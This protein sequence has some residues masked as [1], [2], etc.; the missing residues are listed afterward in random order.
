MTVLAMRAGDQG[1]WTYNPEAGEKLSVGMT[2]VVLGS[3]EQVSALQA[4]TT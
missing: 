2:L 3:A 1:E 4:A